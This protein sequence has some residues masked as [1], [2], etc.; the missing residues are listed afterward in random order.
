MNWF[1]GFVLYFI[2]WWTVLFAVLPL[3]VRPDESG[4][5]TSGGWRGA[6]QNPRLGRKMLITTGVTVVIWLIFFGL[7]QFEWFGFRD[8]IFAI[9]E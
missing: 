7:L 5:A 1:T 2:L 4:D 8:G 3:G 9:R 6:P